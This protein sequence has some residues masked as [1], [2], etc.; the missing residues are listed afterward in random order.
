VN[1]R[2]VGSI[3]NMIGQMSVLSFSR[4]QERDADAGGFQRTVALGYAPQEAPAIWENMV[5]DNKADPNFSGHAFF[6][7]HP[8][9]EERA[10]TNAKWAAEIAPTRNDWRT[11]EDAFHAATAPFLH[12]WVEEELALAQPD[13][14]IAIFRR[15]AANSP[16]QGIYQYGLGE[17]YRKRNQ[18]N[19]LA[20]AENAYRGALA[21][22]DA[23]P[24]AWRG[25]G[26]MAM[27]AGKNAEARDAFTQYRA[28]LPD[29]SDKAMIDF[30][31]TQ[32]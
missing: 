30:Y 1:P 22:A 16:S 14:S 4:D 24:E 20:A 6:S 2:G 12:R 23:P 5:A 18:Q 17:A 29:A 27:K 11:D 13:R 19:D 25:L 8:G 28:K 31:L 10:V 3:G 32:L 15:L 26:L 9:E 7:S 21:T